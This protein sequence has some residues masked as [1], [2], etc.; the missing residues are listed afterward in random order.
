MTRHRPSMHDFGRSC[1]YRVRVKSEYILEPSGN[2]SY[3]EVMVMPEREL[4]G[5]CIAVYG[6]NILLQPADWKGQERWWML[7]YECMLEVEEV[8]L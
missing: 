6:T 7:P 4:V 3:R 2:G 1:Q 5:E 8:K